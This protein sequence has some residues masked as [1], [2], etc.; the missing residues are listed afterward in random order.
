MRGLFWFRKWSVKMAWCDLNIWGYIMFNTSGMPLLYVV[1][2]SISWRDPGKQ[3]FSKWRKMISFIVIEKSRER[4]KWPNFGWSILAFILNHCLGI[5]RHFVSSIFCRSSC[6]I[7]PTVH[8]RFIRKNIYMIIEIMGCF[9][10]RPTV[11]LNLWLHS[12]TYTVHLRKF[13]ASKYNF[14]NTT[15]SQKFSNY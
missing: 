12:T 9:Y 14:I 15:Y 6:M 13:M 2:Y 3:P 1:A 8:V 4:P 5:E 7:D 11:E 10:S